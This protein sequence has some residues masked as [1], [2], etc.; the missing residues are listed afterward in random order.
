MNDRA[1]ITGMI[2]IPKPMVPGYAVDNFTVDNPEFADAQ[3]ANRSTK[4]MPEKLALYRE[5]KKHI[6]FP[7]HGDKSKFLPVGIEL[8]IPDQS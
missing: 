2:Y 1:V 3:R 7:I 6:G 4:G 5:I 8:R